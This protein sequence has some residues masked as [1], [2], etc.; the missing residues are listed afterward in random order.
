MAY[1]SVFRCK[2]QNDKCKSFMISN[3][4]YHLCI[5]CLYEKRYGKKRPSSLAKQN[6]KKSVKLVKSITELAKECLKLQEKNK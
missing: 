3:K 5:E 2:G 4:K 6:K 1:K